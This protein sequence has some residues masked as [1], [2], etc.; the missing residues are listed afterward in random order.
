MNKLI[1]LAA[2]LGIGALLGA[3]LVLL[4]APVSGDTLV[5]NLKAG[6][7]ETLEEARDAAEARRKQLEGEL[8]ARR[9]EPVRALQKTS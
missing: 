2:G 8:K 1:S 7:A 6:Y 3:A 4:F 5:K 9:S